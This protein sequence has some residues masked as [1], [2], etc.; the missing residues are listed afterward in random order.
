MPLDFS[1]M[2]R[3]VTVVESGFL[4]I[5][6]VSN[7]VRISPLGSRRSKVANERQCLF[8][9][10]VVVV[11]KNYVVPWRMNICFFLIVEIIAT[12]P[13]YTVL[14]EPLNFFDDPIMVLYFSTAEFMKS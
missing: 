4:P 12:I 5:F 6:G 8:L 2:V 13:F 9:V 14:A 1:T 3:K 10:R 7:F 11:Q